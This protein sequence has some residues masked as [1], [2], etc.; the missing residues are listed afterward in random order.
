MNDPS[1]GKL[2]L[3]TRLNYLLMCIS[4]TTHVVVVQHLTHLFLTWGLS[5]FKVFLQ[6]KLTRLIEVGVM[7][8]RG[9]AAAWV[10]V[11]Q[12]AHLYSE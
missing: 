6:P 7:H 10:R 8:G 3:S 9:T 12:A 4:W 2:I 5:K 11:V 1:S